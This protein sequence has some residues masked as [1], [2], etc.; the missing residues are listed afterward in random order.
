MYI[1]LPLPSSHFFL[2]VCFCFGEMCWWDSQSA[3]CI[4]LLSEVC[5]NVSGIL[6]IARLEF[7]ATYFTSLTAES[8]TT[9]WK[10]IFNNC[11]LAHP[12]F[13]WLNA[14][15]NNESEAQCT[16]CKRTLKLGTLGVKVLV[17]HAKSEKQRLASK[18]LQRSHAITHCWMP[19]SPVPVLSSS[20]SARPELWRL[21]IKRHSNPLHLNS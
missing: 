2:F 15:L 9:M 12:E 21:V 14:I 4:V 16:L 8:A 5:R 13:S 3:T 7:V 10:C 6:P 20:I 18:S 1:H 19:L 11:W 17:S